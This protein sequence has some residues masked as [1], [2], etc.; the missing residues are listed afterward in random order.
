[1]TACES[2]PRHLSVINSQFWDSNGVCWANGQS[3]VRY[4]CQFRDAN[5]DMLWYSVPLLCNGCVSRELFRYLIDSILYKLTNLQFISIHLTNNPCSS[6]VSHQFMSNH[7][8]EVIWNIHS[9]YDLLSDPRGSSGSS[10]KS[11]R[12]YGATT[13][14]AWTTLESTDWEACHRLLRIQTSTDE[15]RELL[16]FRVRLAAYWHY[17]WW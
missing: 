11:E 8:K 10:L 13:V 1:M 5:W 12:G 3:R 15:N 6:L 2:I 4:C 7:F 14:H 16:G 9:S 17:W